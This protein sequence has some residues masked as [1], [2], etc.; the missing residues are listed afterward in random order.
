MQ[1]WA[2]NVEAVRQVRRECGARQVPGAT[3]VQY[4]NAA[5]IVTS[6]IY[7]GEAN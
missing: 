7:S 2:L 5:P 1:G 3:H 4:M 6:I